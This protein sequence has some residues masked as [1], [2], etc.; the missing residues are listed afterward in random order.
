MK[1]PKPV[2]T[3][4]IIELRQIHL[5]IHAAARAAYNCLVERALQI[6][7]ERLPTELVLAALQAHHLEVVLQDDCVYRPV[8]PLWLIQRLL[9][10]G[11]TLPVDLLIPVIVWKSYDDT[12]IERR[13]WQQVAS[14]ALRLPTLNS[15]GLDLTQLLT[16]IPSALRAPIFGQKITIESVSKITGLSRYHLRSKAKG[17]SDKLK[18]PNA[19]KNPKS[20]KTP[21]VRLVS[22]VPAVHFMPS[23]NFAILVEAP[24]SGTTNFFDIWDKSSTGEL[25]KPAGKD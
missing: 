14:E 23:E 19:P 22:K 8:A 3:C 6:T 15:A 9:Q 4:Q 17:V 2:A 18:M 21:K 5:E 16:S 24:N 11:H 12:E 1:I 20:P 7:G 13:A 10:V 25:R